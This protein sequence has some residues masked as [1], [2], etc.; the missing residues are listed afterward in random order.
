[1]TNHPPL[2][3]LSSS[4]LPQPAIT[5]TAGGQRQRGV[6]LFVILVMVL[7]VTLAALWGSRTALF[8]EF[9]IGNDVDYQRAFEAASAMIEDAEQDI[10]GHNTDGS[11]CEP[12]AT[13]PDV[14]RMQGLA[15]PD[16]QEDVA[17]FLDDILTATGVSSTGCIKGICRKQTNMQDWWED[18]DTFAAMRAVGARYGQFTGAGKRDNA[19][20]NETADDHGAWYWVEVLPYTH[21]ASGVLETVGAAAD[22]PTLHLSLRPRLLY[23]ITAIAKGRREGTMVVL[24]QTYARQRL[25]R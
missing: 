15:F 20:L 23:R 10:R 16:Q 18:K 6:T 21:G 11:E 25:D 5:G 24:Q 3:F 1:M 17:G 8:N 12:Q 9:F 13:R 19:L 7:L 14:C 22:N 2:A 4:R